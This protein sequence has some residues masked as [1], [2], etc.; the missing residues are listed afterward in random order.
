MP[1]SVWKRVDLVARAVVEEAEAKAMTRVVK[2]P[3]YYRWV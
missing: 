1:R 2:E 3:A